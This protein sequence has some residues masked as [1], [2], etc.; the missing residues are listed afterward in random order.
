MN[1]D[2]Q[3]FATQIDQYIDVPV[4]ID[5]YIFVN[6]LNAIDLVGKNIFWAVYDKQADKKLTM[7]VWDLDTT[8][9]QNYN[10][11][12]PHP[13]TVAYDASPLT[14]LKIG[15]LM[16]NLDPDDFN[17]KVRDRYFGLRENIFSADS[18][19]N[20]YRSCYNMVKNCGAACREERRWSGDSDIA[21]LTL[22]FDQ[23][24]DYIE[25]WLR[26]RLE[27]LDKY[28]NHPVAELGNTSLQPEEK[29]ACYTPLG[30]RV[31]KT[32]KGLVITKNG[33]KYFKK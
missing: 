8:V 1:C 17:Q 27:V 30:L 32:Y 24:I 16:V 3:E 33:K 12:P 10:D 18:L 7:A 5:Y 15:W 29:D 6:L 11:L 21:G 19:V 26:H 25:D 2:D 13:E 4:F 9:G 28:F 31:N 14:P 22:D 23:E 20:R